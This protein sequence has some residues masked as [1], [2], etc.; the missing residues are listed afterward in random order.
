MRATLNFGSCATHVQSW[1]AVCRTS[2]VTRRLVSTPFLDKRLLLFRDVS[3]KVCAYD[4]YCP[5]MG[6]DLG[7][8]KRTPEGHIQCR[9]HHWQYDE[10]GRNMT[11][12][13]SP[14]CAE[15][16]LFPF[17]TEERFGFVFVF[18]GPSATFSL[19]PEPP[20]SEY[21]RIGFPSS[22]LDAHPHLVTANGLDLAHFGP[23]HGMPATQTGEVQ[24]DAHSVKVRFRVQPRNWLGHLLGLAQSPQASFQ[25]LG[26]NLS[27]TEL[28][29][30]HGGYLLLA[31]TPC[32]KRGGCET[33]AVLYCQR[34]KWLQ[35]A[36]LVT[37]SLLLA[38]D[39]NKVLTRMKLRPEG[40]RSGPAT[41]RFY[42]MVN[43][44]PTF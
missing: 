2:L 9:F 44:Q 31:N 6:A 14:G 24:E 19:P 36:R 37:L 4:A 35:L 13:N 29:E 34:G 33:R 17:P 40:L 11:A 42:E 27:W 1:Y 38:K 15:S 25:A 28:L 21:V 7:L 26:G 43:R 39:D 5:H 41:G 20:A 3:G 8:A 23:L 16:N 30:P 32:P 18:N 10:S 12:G 22:W